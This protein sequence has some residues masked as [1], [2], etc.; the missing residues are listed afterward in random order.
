MGQ[1]NEWGSWCFCLRWTC[2]ASL[3]RKARVIPRI[4]F[5]LEVCTKICQGAPSG[6][7]SFLTSTC[8]GGISC[9][10]ETSF[11][12]IDVL[13]FPSSVDLTHLR[14]HHFQRQGVKN[15]VCYCLGEA[16]CLQLSYLLTVFKCLINAKKN[17]NCKQKAPKHNH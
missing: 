5:S 2:Y 3:V 15:T 14:V 10:T 4:P 13:G 12:K 1:E 16:F 6:A 9:Q 11:L 7:Y 8:D 17:S